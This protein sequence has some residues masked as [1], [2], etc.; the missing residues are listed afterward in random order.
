M[1]SAARVTP[2]A[3]QTGHAIRD[4]ALGRV[5]ETL[6][7]F[8][9]LNRSVWSEGPVPPSI[10]E[11]MRLT[12]ARHVNC[13]FC[14]SV[15]YD[16]AREDGLTEDKVAQLDH[17]QDSD[18]APREKLAVAFAR[19]YLDDPSGKH[20]DLRRELLTHF[21]AAEVAHMAQAVATF[22]AFSKCA[23]SLGGMPDELPVM[24]MS[25]PEP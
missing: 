24:E 10:L 22:N 3:E 2:P 12:N 17:Y 25:L 14:K 7:A 11:L 5:P 18:L 19:A 6:D 9:Q 15:R 4:S 20:E 23:V 8:I 16:I 1:G 21:S 13:V